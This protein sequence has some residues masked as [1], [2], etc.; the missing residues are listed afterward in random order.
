MSHLFES[1]GSR[2]GG[3]TAPPGVYSALLVQASVRTSLS[4]GECV[5][6]ST[7]RVRVDL[8]G[9][10]LRGMKMRIR[11]QHVTFDD[12]GVAEVSVPEWD[13]EAVHSHVRF[14]R[15]NDRAVELFFTEFLWEPVDDEA[16]LM[17]NLEFVEQEDDDE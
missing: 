14:E 16:F 12:E 2:L 3:L 15:L 9:L 10:V 11:R 6:R 17:E 1:S 7:A 13:S 5:F 4:Y 8:T